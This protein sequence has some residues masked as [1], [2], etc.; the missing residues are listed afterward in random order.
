M[1]SRRVG[2][3]SQVWASG[4]ASRLNELKSRGVVTI[5]DLTVIGLGR[6]IPR[7]R[8]IAQQTKINIIVATGIY[9]YHDAPLYFHFRGPVTALGD[10]ELIFDM[11]VRDITEVITD[12]S[13][14]A[15]IFNPSTDN[16]VFTNYIHRILP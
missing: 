15:S 2:G 1:H 10:P 11:F 13:V 5:A 12:T 8:Q 16:H 4:R 9:T 14:I 6:Y 3:R 7:I